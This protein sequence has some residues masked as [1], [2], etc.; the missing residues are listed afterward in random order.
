MV[1]N[2][3]EEPERVSVHVRRVR[4]STSSYVS[5]LLDQSCSDMCRHNYAELLEGDAL[6]SFS[7]SLFFYLALFTLSDV[8]FNKTC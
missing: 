1:D 3:C 6:L 2:L 4:R 5:T 8:S 7:L